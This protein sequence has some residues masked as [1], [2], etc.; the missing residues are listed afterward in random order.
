MKPNYNPPASYILVLEQLSGTIFDNWLD[1]NFP[2]SSSQNQTPPQNQ[3]PA[4]LR[5]EE[6]SSRT[7]YFLTNFELPTP[8]LNMNLKQFNQDLN[9]KLEGTHILLTTLVQEFQ[10]FKN[11]ISV[12]PQQPPTHIQ[13]PLMPNPHTL[14]ATIPIPNVHQPAPRISATASR[15]YPNTPIQHQETLIPN[16]Y[17]ANSLTIIQAASPLNQENHV[18]NPRIDASSTLNIHQTQEQ[19]KKFL[20]GLKEE[21]RCDILACTPVD[22]REIV[23]LARLFEAKWLGNQNDNKVTTNDEATIPKPVLVHHQ[24]PLLPS[25]YNTNISVPKPTF[26]HLEPKFLFI[27]LMNLMMRVLRP[28]LRPDMIQSL[29]ILFS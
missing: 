9:T 14:Q 8:N 12:I 18:L 29:E 20:D 25:L 10:Q 26:H 19:L 1:P 6:I 4:G 3:D 16:P 28:I 5:Q 15:P 11:Q 27:Q 24:K 23:Y 17:I 21:I 2:N 13:E 22:L 7:T